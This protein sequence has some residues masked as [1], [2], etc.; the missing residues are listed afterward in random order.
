MLIV[1][2]AGVH[3]SDKVMV[4]GNPSINYGPYNT[5]YDA[6]VS[7]VTDKKEVPLL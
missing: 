2:F 6:V 1:H 3:Q 4:L 7:L 5:P